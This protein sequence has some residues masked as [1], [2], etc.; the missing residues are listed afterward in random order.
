MSFLTGKPAKSSSVNTNNAAIS[1]DYSGQIGQGTNA[2]NY[3]SALLTGQGDTAGANA[4]YQNYLQ[5]A[6]YAPAM[7]QLSQ[8]I[9]GQG[10]AAGLLN[11]GSTAKALQSSGAALNNQYYNNYLQ[12][13]AGLSGLGLQAGGLVTQAG[14][15]SSST[16]GTSGVLGS[17]GSVLGGLGAIGNAG[18]FGAI[19]SDRRLKFDI[20]LSKRDDDGLGWYT[21]RYKKQ[22]STI[23]AGVMADEVAKIRPWALGPVIDGYATVNYGAL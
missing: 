18:G 3:L 4:G 2:T 6:G 22:P 10:A 7:K 21:F 11:S 19:F 13:L 17:A 9:T 20:K 16:G 1:S 12:S 5:Q 14:Q 8:G 15:T 23:I